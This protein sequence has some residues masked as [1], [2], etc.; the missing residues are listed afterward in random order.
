MEIINCKDLTEEQ[1]NE[2]CNLLY[3][4]RILYIKHKDYI[5]LYCEDDIK[6]ASYFY[7]KINFLL[8]KVK[9]EIKWKFLK[10]K[11]KN[12]IGILRI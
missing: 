11:K 1:I 10:R 7:K 5:E 12:Y 3:H 9:E 4:Y 2:L 6:K 8:K